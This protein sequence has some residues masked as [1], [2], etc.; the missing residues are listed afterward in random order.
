MSELD[1]SAAP[2]CDADKARSPAP[3]SPE[4]ASGDADR[5][6]PLTYPEIVQETEAKGFPTSERTLR[7][8]V[9]EGL[10]PPPGT[11]GGVPAFERAFILGA[12]AAIDLMRRRFELTLGEAR[13]VM[14]ALTEEPEA[15]AEKLRVIDAEVLTPA[16]LEGVAALGEVDRAGAE[17]VL[18]RFLD[19][20][21][22]QGRQPSDI[23]V[24]D[25]VNEEAER[26]VSPSPEP[27][28]EAAGGLSVERVQALE[29][30]FIGRFDE[31][32]ARVARLPHPLDEALYPAGPRDR[33]HLKRT[34][35]DE[36]VDLM[37]RHRVYE[38]ELLDL[39][40][41]DE[42]SEYR[43]FT[44]SIFGRRDVRVVVAAASVSPLEELI[45]TRRAVSPAGPAELER[46]LG[47]IAPRDG[48]FYYI[49]VLSPTGWE[50]GAEHH[51]PSSPN[52]LVCLVEP[53]E[54]TAWRQRYQ[55]TQRWSGL[56]R[57][58]D[59]ESEREKV[60]RAKRAILAEPELQLRGGHVALKGL[61][62]RLGVPEGVLEAAVSDVVRRDPD[63]SVQDV[64]GRTILKR[65]RL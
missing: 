27:G 48:A 25:L 1:P 19:L 11:R 49:G 34:R 50:P 31:T 32:M 4:P 60:E 28:A 51:V 6:E 39:L 40:P 9:T 59:P 65:R 12:L 41:L 55:S 21:V 36:V 35:S 30:L 22:E 18:R 14:R 20:I 52:V 44:R 64:A 47:A 61:K 56:F 38:R 53:G 17:A 13:S 8:Y 16:R 46:A 43:I 37:K 26:G 33:I 5:P 42:V 2:A 58:F 45:V 29:E 3:D 10:L 62:D 23:S 15:L 57:L 54:G 63:L 7:L 24:L